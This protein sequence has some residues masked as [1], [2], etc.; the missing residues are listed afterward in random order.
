VAQD[1][2]GGL[3]DGLT[4]KIIKKNRKAIALAKTCV[5]TPTLINI[6]ITQGA[7]YALPL[8]VETNQRSASAE[9]SESLVIGTDVKKNITDNVAPG[10]QSWHLTGYIQGIKRLEPTN[11]YQPFVQLHTDIL[12]Q[13]FEK[14]AILIYKDGNAQI[15][16]K[17][18]IKDLQ[19]AQ[20]K[21]SANATPFT[22]TLKELNV[23]NTSPNNVEDN[24][25]IDVNK[26]M[27]SQPAI[28]SGLGIPATFGMTTAAITAEIVDV[29][30]A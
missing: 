21:D 19:T 16:D 20:Q 5:T 29:A 10:A 25:N 26:Q 27:K 22:L 4:L 7:V 23:M 9:V 14:G 15:H 1:K 13:W 3:M 11:F 17:V 28:G 12:W 2:N 30:S 18:V 24:S 8:A 6:D